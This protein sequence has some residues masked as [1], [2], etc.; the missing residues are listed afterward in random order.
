[1]P[2]PEETGGAALGG[3]IDERTPLYSRLAALSAEHPGEPLPGR[4]EDVLGPHPEE[5][6]P[7]RPVE[8]DGDPDTTR[9]DT[10]LAPR[11]TRSLRWFLTESPRDRD[12]LRQLYPELVGAGGFAA[13]ATVTA[14]S[15]FGD[16]APVRALGR[17][18]CRYAADRG[19]VKL[20]LQLL[21]ETATASEAV[22]APAADVELFST[23]ALA[24]GTFTSEALRALK[25]TL[26]DPEPVVFALAKRL[27][28]WGLGSAV[29]ALEHTTDPVIKRWMVRDVNDWGLI[30]YCDTLAI[31]GDLL[32]QLRD[33]PLDDELLDNAGNILTHLCDP[34]VQTRGIEHYPDGRAALLLYQRL[35]AE[36]EPGLARLWY[37][38]E[39]EKSIRTGPASR[40]DWETGEHESLLDG[41]AVLLADPAWMEVVAAELTNPRSNRRYFA[42]QCAGRVGFDVIAWMLDSLN[43][44]AP[45]DGLN[46]DVLAD[47]EAERL[48]EIVAA[49][50]RA[51]RQPFAEEFWTAGHRALHALLPRLVDTGLGYDL[52]EHAL[53]L[54]NTMLS[55][56]A[57][58]LLRRRGS[59]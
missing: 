54:G 45:D 34:H 41:F 8:A 22:D 9:A 25:W 42:S 39:L 31:S 51:V 50:R 16:P 19:P 44:D 14:L 1:M 3:P 2:R 6:E 49:L 15:P 12:A 17:W 40:L 11:L 29:T 23:L 55:G 58:Q 27:R 13:R 38:T 46:W 24:D 33:G 30:Y 48:P 52:V 5:P 28:D 20:G 7:V 59:T 35:L 26:P 43:S 47:C 10:W 53:A 21:A 18:L 57:R 37:L 4:S 32:G 36:H 56:K